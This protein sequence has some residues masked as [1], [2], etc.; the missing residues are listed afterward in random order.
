MQ[1]EDVQLIAGHKYPS[2][3]EM[4]KRKDINEQLELINKYHPLR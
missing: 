2:S 1:L 4:Y 3:T